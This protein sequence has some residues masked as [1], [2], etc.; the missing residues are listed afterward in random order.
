MDIT[1]S[2]LNERMAL[3]VPSELPL[4]LVFIVGQVDAIQPT[5][6]ASGE[7]ALRLADG[8]HSLLCRLP[9]QVA[10]EMQLAGNERVRAGGHLVFDTREARYFLLARDIE[11]LPPPGRDDETT[12]PS[13]AV[14]PVQEPVDDGRLVA[15][16]LPPWVRQLAPPEVQ[17]ELGMMPP[18]AAETTPSEDET[19]P[20]PAA[21]VDYLSQAIDSDQ[22]VELTPTLFHE[23]VERFNVEPA[24]K[25]AARSEA[26]RDDKAFEEGQAAEVIGDEK[27]APT[28]SPVFADDDS[29][30]ASELPARAPAHPEPALA[31]DAKG[32]GSS[33][34]RQTLVL[35]GAVLAFLVVILVV[36]VLIALAAGYTPFLLP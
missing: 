4:G 33:S 9:Q 19:I 5:F 35:I 1:V 24:G 2:R 22:E 10:E 12:P 13:P 34:Q 28:V 20:L 16:D 36:F 25:V 17:S 31:R 26:A 32:R 18:A 3:R 7:V 6:Q 15:A 29:V 21:L 27:P 30:P 8:N 23:L 11:V 14:A